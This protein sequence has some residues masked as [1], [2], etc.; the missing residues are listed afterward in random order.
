MSILT[1]ICY[2]PPPLRTLIPSAPSWPRRRTAPSPLITSP[3]RMSLSRETPAAAS[4]ARPALSLL[5][6]PAWCSPSWV[7]LSPGSDRMW[8]LWGSCQST[9]PSTS[10]ASWITRTWCTAAEWALTGVISRRRWKKTWSSGRSYGKRSCSCRYVGRFRVQT[11][12][13]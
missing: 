5:I 8:I 1:T 7:K 10:W 13:L 3:W 9:S 2:V 11:R 4:L 6:L 12:N